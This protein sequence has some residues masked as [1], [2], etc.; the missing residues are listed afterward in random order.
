MRRKQRDKKKRKSSKTRI[1]RKKTCHFCTTKVEQLDFKNVDRL[2]RFT[3]EKG[4]IVP[5][6]ISG[7]CAKHQ[8][9]LSKAIKTARIACL[10]PFT[11]E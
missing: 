11:S 2:S 9:R 5:R 8:R 3:T 4:K 7:A 10:M 6:R 1:F